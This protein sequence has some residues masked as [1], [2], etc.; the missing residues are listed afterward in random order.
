MQTY[1][2]HRGSLTSLKDIPYEVKE[3]L[4]SKSIPNVLRGL[5]MSP[6]RKR[7]YVLQGKIYDFFINP[8]TKEKKELL[9]NTG[10]YVDIPANWAH[11]FYSYENSEI[12]YLLEDK[13]D[14]LL[15]KTIYWNSLGLTLDFN[16]NNLILSEKD[17]N[18]SYF[19][20]YDYFVL[21]A[22]GFLGSYCVNILKTQGYSV[23]ESNERLYNTRLIEEQIIK[24]Q[25]K[26]V[27]CAAGISGKPTIDW[28]EYNE[29]ETYKTNY[30]GMI[31]LMRLTNKLNIHFTIFGSALIYS[32]IKQSYSEDDV[33]DYISKVYSKWR[34]QLE[35]N[36]NFY[37]NTLY[38][39]I[40]YPATL[41]SNN[42]CFLTKMLA[43]AKNVHNI[44]VSMTIVPSLFPKIKELCESNRVGIYNFVNE[45]TISLP[46]L[47][48]LYSKYKNTIEININTEGDSRGGYELLTDKLN[49][50]I[51]NTNV[52]DAIINHII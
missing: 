2:D 10:E 17:A 33:P 8:I 23:Y 22:K 39:R 21:G 27:I 11:G 4:I 41:D 48:E 47:L 50:I 35:K 30:I 46:K 37:K 31:D 45:G 15:D 52:T 19:Q 9:V 3:I 49:T 34:I 32:G 16:K 13:F 25:A 51:N 42:K 14:P 26:Y 12:L 20:K 6:Y 44:N 28:C 18:A 5:H 38:L 1:E 40:I 29:E 24:S 36:I 7:V 43:R